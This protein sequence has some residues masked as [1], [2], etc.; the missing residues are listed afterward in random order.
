MA[1]VVVTAAA[2][3]GFCDESETTRLSAVCGFWTTTSSATELTAVAGIVEV[4]SLTVVI[5]VF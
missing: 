4:I 5:I 3:D 1:A 2:V